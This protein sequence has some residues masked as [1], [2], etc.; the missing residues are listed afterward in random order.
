MSRLQSVQ[1]KQL[2]SSS[3]EC[4]NIRNYYSN[5]Q[6]FVVKDLKNNQFCSRKIVAVTRRTS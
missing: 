5:P 2:F 1:P 3:N 6:S 4:E